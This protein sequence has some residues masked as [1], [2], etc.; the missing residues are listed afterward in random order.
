VDS[1]ELICDSGAY[2]LYRVIA[3]DDPDNF[4]YYIDPPFGKE[5]RVG[6]DGKAGSR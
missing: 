1:Q 4:E 5:K 6:C 2:K 3:A